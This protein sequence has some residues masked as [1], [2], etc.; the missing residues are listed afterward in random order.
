M[1]KEFEITSYCFNLSMHHSDIYPNKTNSP[2][3]KL[4]YKYTEI[5]GGG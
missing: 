1:Q 3:Y 5:H 2:T 4:T